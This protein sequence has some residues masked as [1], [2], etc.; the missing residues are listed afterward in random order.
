MR[1]LEHA[2]AALLL[3]EGL[4]DDSR[5]VHALVL[6][7]TLG[8]I[9]G[10]ARVPQLAVRAC[11]LAKAVGDESLLQDATLTVASILAASLRLDEARDLLEHAPG[12]R[13]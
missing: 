11:E 9:A 1:A 4:D 12:A 8:Y 7:C 6:Q 13:A 3:A 10:D 5:R 2:N